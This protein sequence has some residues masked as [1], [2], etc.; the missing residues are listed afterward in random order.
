MVLHYDSA[1]PLIARSINNSQVEIYYDNDIEDNQPDK[2]D[3][4]SLSADTMGII[5]VVCTFI[6]VIIG[7]F[8]YLFRNNKNFRRYEGIVNIADMFRSN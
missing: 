7:I 1:F 2:I 6:A 4:R 5:F 3:I 8:T